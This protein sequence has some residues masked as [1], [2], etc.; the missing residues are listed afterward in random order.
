MSTVIKLVLTYLILSSHE[1]KFL[2][3]ITKP[4]A[5]RTWSAVWGLVYGSEEGSKLLG[6]FDLPGDPGQDASRLIVE[7]C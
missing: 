2:P 1:R 3:S 5:V 7:V 6:F 4:V